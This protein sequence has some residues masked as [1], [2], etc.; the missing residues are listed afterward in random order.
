MPCLPETLIFVGFINN[1]VMLCVV[2]PGF[3]MLA[4]RNACEQMPDF[5][6]RIAVLFFLI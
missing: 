1:R 3:N 2:C 5:I 6:A 4:G